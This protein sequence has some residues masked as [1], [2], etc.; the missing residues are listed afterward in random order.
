MLWIVTNS[1]K[2][3]LSKLLARVVLRNFTDYYLWRQRTDG[4]V[5]NRRWGVWDAWQKLIELHKKY[6]N[7]NISRH[8]PKS[9]GY[10]FPLRHCESHRLSP[11]VKNQRFIYAQP[12]YHPER[13]QSDLE[14]I[15]QGLLFTS[16]FVRL[17]Y[18][19]RFPSRDYYG[20]CN[21]TDHSKFTS[22]S[23]SMPKIC[24]L[25]RPILGQHKPPWTDARRALCRLLGFG[26]YSGT[27]VALVNNRTA[28]LRMLRRYPETSWFRILF[29]LI[30]S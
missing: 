12:S 8:G 30:G 18:V 1:R 14:L 2:I 15:T 27:F 24:L 10:F 6:Q 3:L 7:C 5:D 17:C 23:M 16:A 20:L 28:M 22:T 29:A 25:S 21:W 26:I 13:K 4:G 19:R 9:L 11:A